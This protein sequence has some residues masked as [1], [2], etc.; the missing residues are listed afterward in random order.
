MVY[1]AYSITIVLL[2]DF[3]PSAVPMVQLVSVVKV[4]VQPGLCSPGS[5]AFSRALSQSIQAGF[6]FYLFF[7]LT[8]GVYTRARAR[9]AKLPY[10]Q[11]RSKHLGFQLFQATTIVSSA[12]IFL[13]A[14]I[15]V[16]ISPFESWVCASTL[17]TCGLGITNTTALLVTGINSLDPAFLTAYLLLVNW[18][19][20]LAQ[21]YLPAGSTWCLTREE[22][23]SAFERTIV[24]ALYE[25]PQ[26]SD[27]KL[28]NVHEVSSV[29]SLETEILLFNLTNAV[30][31]VNS[32]NSKEENA[33][34]LSD[35]FE[36]RRYI[37]NSETDTHALVC[38]R[39]DRIVLAFR[40]TVSAANVRTDTDF[41]MVPYF[42]KEISKHEDGLFDQIMS[43]LGRRKP[44]VHSGF[45]KAIQSVQSEVFMELNQL[46]QECD[47]P[48]M[49][50]GTCH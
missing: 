46:L 23:S 48:V 45:L 12:V 21:G 8:G 26:W 41:K 32:E 20:F 4:C 5:I 38:S 3:I 16:L 18:V 22:T 10:A 44:L 17:P 31:L 33:E 28:D 49:F 50:T 29:F 1:V 36:M 27:G 9:L 34:C 47:R 39:E 2:F 35:G 30:Y 7:I 15:T 43:A 37:V 13:Y 42:D 11:Y 40:G 25:P 6:E 19:F 14:I 24:Y